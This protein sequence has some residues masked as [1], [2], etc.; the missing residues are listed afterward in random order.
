MTKAK[1]PA[2]KRPPTKLAILT[3][4]LS[5]E[6]GADVKE[7][8]KATG[9]LAH[10]VRGAIAGSLKHKGLRI[11]STLE[12]DR[13]VYRIVSAPEPIEAAQPEPEA[14]VA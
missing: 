5:R 7:M 12:G 11:E 14:A 13:R 9:W 2:A 1:A 10:S 4:L 3:K 6:R 8:M